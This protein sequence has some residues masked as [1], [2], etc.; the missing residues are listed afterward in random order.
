MNLR[1]LAALLALALVSTAGAADKSDK[2]DKPKSDLVPPDKRRVTVELGVRLTQPPTP[3][4]L[5]ADLAQPFNPPGFD[6]PDR[7]ERPPAAAAGAGRGGGEDPN[8][9]ARPAPIA[10]DRETLESLAARIVP[11]GTI[12]F[13]GQP[14]L[15][16]GNSRLRVGA[17]FT[18]TFNGQDYDLELTAINSTTFTLRYHNEEIT[19]SIKPGK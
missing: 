13:G 3:E 19:R 11:K 4:P 18:V 17:H 15:N 5:P 16:I 12:I 14:L 10:G 1:S 6:L 2:S 8:A 9:P 7:E